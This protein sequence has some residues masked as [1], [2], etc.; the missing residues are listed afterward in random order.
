[1]YESP[2]PRTGFAP[3][4]R[5]YKSLLFDTRGVLRVSEHQTHAFR[6]TFPEFARVHTIL[7]KSRQKMKGDVLEYDTLKK[8]ATTSFDYIR[9]VIRN[10]IVTSRVTS[11]FLKISYEILIFSKEFYN[12]NKKLEL[13]LLMKIANVKTQ[14]AFPVTYN[15]LH[16]NN[17]HA[18]SPF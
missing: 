12:N 9:F 15:I 5:L 7:L 14:A 13:L 11:M 1:M 8:R 17:I 2:N 18:S 10:C 3:G 6:Q 4:T 16:I